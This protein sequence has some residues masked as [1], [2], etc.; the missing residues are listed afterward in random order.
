MLNTVERDKNK[1]CVI[2]LH[3]IIFILLE[4]VST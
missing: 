1:E 3:I 4:F 2:L